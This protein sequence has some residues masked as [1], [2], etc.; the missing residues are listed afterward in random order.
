M[1]KL[2]KTVIILIGILLASCSSD[3]SNE[4]V[5]ESSGLLKRMEINDPSIIPYVYEFYYN[6]NS[7]INEIYFYNFF[8]GD[9][10]DKFYYD[11]QGNIEYVESILLSNNQVVQTVNFTYNSSGQLINEIK[12]DNINNNEVIER[13]DYFFENGMLSCMNSCYD[14]TCS[15]FQQ[16]CYEYDGNGNSIT[17]TYKDD[18][19]QTLFQIDITEFDNNKSPYFGSNIAG[20][21]YTTNPAFGSLGFIDDINNPLNRS[22]TTYFSN[23]NINLEFETNY[24]IDFNSSDLPTQITSNANQSVIRF[25]SYEYY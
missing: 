18:N 24:T 10:K 2:I 25:I 5:P 23:G 1:K 4:Q 16:V 9:R 13:R 17:T 14:S 6:D 22:V 21:I 7:T 19:G 11:N 8:A 15:S 20:I 12:I 3:D